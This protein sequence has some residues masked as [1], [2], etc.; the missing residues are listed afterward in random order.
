MHFAKESII[1]E[2][3]LYFYRLYYAF[4][5]IFSLNYKSSTNFTGNNKN[6]NIFIDYI[7]H[8]LNFRTLFSL[9]LKNGEKFKY[10]FLLL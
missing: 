8:K 4:E 2:Y 7:L 6:K 5:K 9:S 10:F 1:L 3:Y